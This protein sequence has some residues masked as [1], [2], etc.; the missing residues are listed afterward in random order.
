M[1]LL[2]LAILP[3]FL[4][5][6]YYYLKDTKK[7]PLKLL[8]KLFFSGI[9]SGLIVIVISTIALI[10]F[11]NFNN[12]EELNLKDI[13]IYSFLFVAVLE[14]FFKWLMVYKITYNHQEYDQLYDI[15]LYAVFVGLGFACF[16]NIIYIYQSNI[17]MYL[18]LIRGVTAIPAHACF[19]TSMGYFLTLS[20]YQKKKKYL[21]YSIFI[22]IVLHGNY[23]FILLSKNNVLNI[24]FLFY[25]VSLFLIS[26]LELK[27]IIKL[28]KKNN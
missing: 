24:F 23:D 25:L 28:D 9:L 27:K 15:I 2:V 17:G 22:P 19:A 18:A 21:Y 26:I 8:K 10:I 12:I 16:E 13:F 11:P 20:K 14:E 1:L 3:I 4:I 7:E 6:Y 5:G